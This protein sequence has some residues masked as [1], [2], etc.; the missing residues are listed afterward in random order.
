[1]SAVGNQLKSLRESLGMSQNKIAGLL[2]VGQSTVNRYE[3][4]QSEAPYKVLLWYADY[5]DVSLDYIFGRTDQPQGKLYDY[6]PE[7]VKE[8]LARQEDWEAFVEACFEPG[9]PMN[10]KL[11]QM[12]M[13]M[14]EVI[15]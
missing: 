9:T 2:S 1:M 3:Q 15:D 13:N 12:L 6:Q 7:K 10:E 4:E 11:K 8:Q 14:S 5:F